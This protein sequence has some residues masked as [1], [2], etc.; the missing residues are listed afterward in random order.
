MK[1]ILALILLVS[2]LGS[3]MFTVFADE[4]VLISEEE[5]VVM[6]EPVSDKMLVEGVVKEVTEE[7][8]VLEDFALNIG[9]QTLIAG[10]DLVPVEVKE[11][12]L[13]TAVVSTM[14]TRSLPPQAFAFYVIV[15]KDAMDNAPIYMTVEKVEE[16]MIYSQDGSYEVTYENVEVAMYKTKNIVKAEELTKGSEIFVYADMMTMSIPALVNPQKIV[17]MSVAQPSKAEILNQQ[18]ILL[19]TEKGLE[20]EREVSRA[21]AVTLIW[22]TTPSNR[23][24]Y[25]SN[26]EDVSET[27]WA[28]SNISWA[29]ETKIVNGIGDN[30]FA[31]DRSVTAK[32]LAMMLLNAI[33]ETVGF[34]NAFEVACEK[35]F[36][37]ED[38]G[39]MEDDVLTREATAM[40]IY[41][42]INR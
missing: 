1:R 40:M 22:R 18:G 11:G 9:E 14:T 21:E 28:Y 33:G 35:G 27:H 3:A 31:P 38:D 26:F 36:V 15:K 42:Y 30:K 23:M 12:D 5:A 29:Y 8:I 10:T 2:V 37:T 41:N 13:V 17:V 16:G 20:L 34:E 32:E 39:I 25:K 24:V 4:P 6:P 19:G 7:Q